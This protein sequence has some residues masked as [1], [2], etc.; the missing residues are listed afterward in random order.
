MSY[1]YQTTS[2]TL[3]FY[4]PESQQTHS[5]LFSPR[6]VVWH[7]YQWKPWFSD[8]QS[9]EDH[10]DTPTRRERD[11]EAAVHKFLG[12]LPERLLVGDCVIDPRKCKITVSRA[13]VMLEPKIEMHHYNPDDFA[14]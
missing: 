8:P 12:S 3:H 2:I 11:N 13:A 9:K 10:S 6:N 4:D 1:Q 14:Y 5:R 7:H